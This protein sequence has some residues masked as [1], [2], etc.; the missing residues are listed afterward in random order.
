[1]EYIILELIPTTQDIKTGEIVQLSALKIKDLD[2]IDRFDYRL[3]EDKIYLKE[4]VD[5]FSYNKESFIYKNSTKEIMDEFK[6]FIKDTPLLILDNKYTLNYLS[7]IENKKESIFNH[8]NM[9][10]HDDIIDDVIK[11]YNLQ[12]S[13]Y[14]VDLLFEALIYE[15]NKNIDKI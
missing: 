14:I 12:P 7:E 8:L 5:I 9:K 13:E 3:T 2:L 4:L 11:K 1:M 6:K 15:S 10:Y